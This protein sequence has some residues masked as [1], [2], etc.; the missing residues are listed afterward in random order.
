MKKPILA[1]LLFAL[2]LV[3]AS[4]AQYYTID[5]TTPHIIT[6]GATVYTIYGDSLF[7]MSQKLNSNAVTLAASVSALNY[8]VTNYIATNLPPFTN[9]SA[10][11]GAVNGWGI[12]TNIPPLYTNSASPMGIV[13]GFGIG[14]NQVKGIT[15]NLQMWA[16]DGSW[17]NTLRFSAG[18]LTNVTS[19]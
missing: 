14:T 13:V 11:A 8:L 7:V 2:A 15:T 1:V 6:N 17:T 4:R 19:P 12:G 18:V 9:T 5:T 16:P 3:M 10:G